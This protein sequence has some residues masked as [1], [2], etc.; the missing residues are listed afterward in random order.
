MDIKNDMRPWGS[1]R[2][3]TENE[4]TTIKIISVNAGNK[5]SLQYHN[6]RSEFWVVL[7]GNPILTIGEERR[8]AQPKQEFFIPQKTK[9][10]IEAIENN[11]EILE[12]AFGNFD[13][14]DI[15][16]IEDSYGRI[17]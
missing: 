16:R 8:Q 6:N 4:L 10:R 15:V 1:F 12:I 7:E 14:S 5:L 11:V 9:H 13:E 17:S 3:F 2:Q